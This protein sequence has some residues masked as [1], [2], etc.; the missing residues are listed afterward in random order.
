MV[1]IKIYIEGGGDGRDLESRFREAWTKFFQAAGLQGKMPRTVRGKGRL[2]TYEL[3]CTALEH[4]K[5][6]ELILLL[7]DSEEPVSDGHSTWQHLKKRDGWDKPEKAAA[8]Q[9]H[10]MTQVMETWLIADRDALSTYFGNKFKPAKIPAWPNLE[11][12][13]KQTIFDALKNASADCGEKQYAK[14]KVSFEILSR[15]SPEKLEKHCPSAARFL[16][17][18]KQ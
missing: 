12:V 3:F 15:I 13:A 5:K 14:G 10:L 6:D 9:A 1:N 4:Q 16:T 17:I 7:V 2:N 8:D 11:A 18:L